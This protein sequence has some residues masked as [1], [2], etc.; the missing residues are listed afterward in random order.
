M[1][2]GLCGPQLGLFR[3]DVAESRVEPLAIVVAFD[4]GEQIPLGVVARGIVL[5]MDEFRLPKKLSMG[6]LM[7]L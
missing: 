3:G 5:S 7:L 1:D 2:T 6:A 4:V